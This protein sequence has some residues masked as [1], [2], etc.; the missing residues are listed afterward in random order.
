[1]AISDHRH[2]DRRIKSG[3]SGSGDEGD[4]TLNLLVANQA[5]SQLSYVPERSAVWTPP[6]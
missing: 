2:S 1:M 6:G 4:R 5:L 3:R